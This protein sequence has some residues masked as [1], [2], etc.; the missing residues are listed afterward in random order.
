MLIKRKSNATCFLRSLMTVNDNGL[1]VALARR[2]C[3]YCFLYPLAQLCF[4]GCWFEEMVLVA[5]LHTV[6]LEEGYKTILQG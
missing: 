1:L 6:R 4:Y 3:F 5:L 2:L